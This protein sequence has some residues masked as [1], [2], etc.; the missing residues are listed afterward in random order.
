MGANISMM[1]YGVLG[2]YA[3]EWNSWVI[4]VV[5][6]LISEKSPNWFPQCLH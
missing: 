1:G 3:H 4:Y 6:F 2:V 5:L